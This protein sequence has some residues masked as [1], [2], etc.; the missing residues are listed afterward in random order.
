M[1][2]AKA[3]LIE[4]RNGNLWIGLSFP[5]GFDPEEVLQETVRGNESV[6]P[7]EMRCS[8]RRGNINDIYREF[9]VCFL[10]QAVTPAGGQ[11]GTLYITGKFR[12]GLRFTASVNGLPANAP[13]D[14]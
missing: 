13:E 7:A 5:T 6:T 14:H 9:E 11:E 1:I 12:R 4:G 2:L 3:R 8:P 10:P